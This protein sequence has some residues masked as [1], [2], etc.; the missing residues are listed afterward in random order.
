[1][2]A[3]ELK[4]KV[5]EIFQHVVG[6]VGKPKKLVAKA[7]PALDLNPYLINFE[8]DHKHETLDAGFGRVYQVHT[9]MELIYLTHLQPKCICSLKS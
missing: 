8:V 5:D 9:A 2:N 4:S 7:A 6:I 1:M 3:E